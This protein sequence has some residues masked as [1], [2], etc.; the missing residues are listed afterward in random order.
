[1]ASGGGPPRAIAFL[2][3]KIAAAR[4]LAGL[5]IREAGYRAE[6]APL[7]YFEHCFP[8]S[9]LEAILMGRHQAE[10]PV[11]APVKAR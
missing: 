5:G 8:D 11:H 2:F 3:R 10:C 6:S 4:A 9:P 1:M 7:G